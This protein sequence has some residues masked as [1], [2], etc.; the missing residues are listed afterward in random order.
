MIIFL[1]GEDNWR[2]IQRKREIIKSFKEQNPDIILNIINID[3]EESS[4]DSFLEIIRNQSIFEN[5]KFIVLSGI[6]SNENKNDKKLSEE[7]KIALKNNNLH[8][9]IQ[10]RGKPPENFSF[11]LKKPV[12]HEEFKRLKGEK[13]RDF[14]LN[15]IKKRNLNLT[16][17]ALNLIS[18]VYEGNSFALITELDKIMFLNK[19]TIDLKDLNDIDIEIKP[20]FDFIFKDLASSN[21]KQ[22]LNA[23]ENL[24]S[25]REDYAKIFNI[26]AYFWYEKT[27]F[28][29]VYDRAIKS[30]KLNYEEA[31]LDIIL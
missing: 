14:V 30:G 2:K 6:F 22:R 18:K 24:I 10:E 29:A 17:S 7:M 23:F 11:L 9:L 5:K 25:L 16:T 26:L 1:Y 21:L 3:L 19:K 27:Q 15:E 31:L 28:F 4:I 20:D 8:I 13:W 12:M